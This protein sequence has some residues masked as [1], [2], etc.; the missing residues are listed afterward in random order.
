[1]QCAE[2]IDRLDYCLTVWMR[3]RRPRLRTRCRE[4]SRGILI[5]APK[6]RSPVQVYPSSWG[7]DWNVN[8]LKLNKL[9]ALRIGS[10][11]AGKTVRGFVKYWLGGKADLYVEVVDPYNVNNIEAGWQA[12]A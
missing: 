7:A 6:P 11:T 3:S 10:V 1:M 5:G 9:P 8:Y 12:P 4:L 2:A